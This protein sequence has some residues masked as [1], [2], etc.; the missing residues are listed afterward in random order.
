LYNPKHFEET[1]VDVLHDHVRS[2]PLATFVTL[3]SRGLNA[4]HLPLL[5]K[6]E[7]GPFGALHG[8][9]S[10]ANPVWK[11][12]DSSVD[13]LAIFSGPS[14]YISPSWY[15]TKARNGEAVPTWN[16]AVVHAYGRVRIVED[17]EWLRTH[18]DALSR[19]H[20]DGR[21]EP[22]TIADAP[23]KYIDRLLGGIVGFEIPV[24]RLE[25]K[26]KV[27]QN[28]P[29]ENRA[30]V[31]SGLTSSGDAADAAVA[32]LVRDRGPS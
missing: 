18:V 7:P 2:H 20:E 22:W 4:N 31:V 8:H 23:G 5:L 26:W 13:A 32:A 1:R 14:A 30:G 16:Y 3:T 27:S 12:L 15:P 17:P 24:T 9:V 19:A 29:A 11:D 28:H 10:R 25:G 6:A 21:P